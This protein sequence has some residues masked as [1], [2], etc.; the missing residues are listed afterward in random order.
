M[1]RGPSE[2][3]CRKL[4]SFKLNK[5]LELEL[6][7][8][9]SLLYSQIYGVAML[10]FVRSGA[11]IKVLAFL[12][13]WTA[14]FP[15]PSK[16]AEPPPF[17]AWWPIVNFE[18]EAGGR[19]FYAV[20]GDETRDGESKQRYG[21]GAGVSDWLFFELEGE[22][23][24]APGGSL[25][26]QAYEVESRIELTKTKAFN[27]APNPLDV[28]LLFGMSVPRN[29]GDAYEAEARLLLYRRAGPWRSTGNIIIEKEFGNSRAG[30]VEFAYA[31]QLR[32]RLTRNIQPGFEA[33]GRFGPVDDLSI[34]DQQQKIGPGVFGFIE[35]NDD[36]ALKYEVS[37][38]FGVTGPTP[39]HSLK[40]LAEFE[41]KY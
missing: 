10:Q 28:G 29:G 14:A 11:I 24:K 3:L 37:W 9:L 22:Y 32:Y 38:L 35:V 33:F 4:G 20:D 19:G 25:E 6:F 7:H 2:S 18:V 23:Q 21:F 31:G 30:E 1:F 12:F 27:E 16:A 36:V 34:R 15:F 13:L 39:A 40:W 41:Y 17:R 8:C 5:I 26:F